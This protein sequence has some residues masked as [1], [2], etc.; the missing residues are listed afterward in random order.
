MPDLIPLAPGTLLSSASKELER[1]ILEAVPAGKRA[2]LMSIVDKDGIQ[3]GIAATWKGRV[4]ASLSVGKD[5]N[6]TPPTASLKVRVS[7]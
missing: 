4:Y 3:L 6:D 1:Q 2:S 5:W 7:F